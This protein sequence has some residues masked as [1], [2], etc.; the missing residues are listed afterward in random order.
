VEPYGVLVTVGDNDTFPLWYAQSVEG[1]RRDVVIANTSLLNTDWYVRQIIRRPIYE[2]DA[3]KGPAIYRGK[4]WPKPPTAPLK[5][6]MDEADSIPPY[7]TLDRPMIFRSSDATIEATIDPK[8]LEH[9]V[10]ERADLFVLR[11]IQD[12]WPNRP[13]YFARTSGSYARSLGLGEYVLTQGLA[14]KVFTPPKGAAALA[15]K[16]SVFVQGDGWFDVTRSE[17]LWK[18]VFVG[19]KSVLKTGDW[20]DR[21]SVGIP[22]LYVATGV[23]LAQEL[24]LRGQNAEAAQVFQTA[25][26]IADAVRLGDLVREAE[27]AFRNPL[28]PP[29]GDTARAAPIP[30]TGG[31]KPPPAA[32]ATEPARPKKK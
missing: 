28:V 22:Y 27:A 6:T 20:I 2:Y 24:R 7:M 25:K 23:E 13:I 4:Q 29:M 18:D 8:Q 11:M 32:Q 3:A 30:A 12:S 10:L 1:V 19:P 15:A 17:A 16:D 21:P 14:S 26:S 5:M 9:G 31:K